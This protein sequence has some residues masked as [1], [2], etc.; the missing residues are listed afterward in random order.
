MTKTRFDDIL[1]NNYS[2]K[3]SEVFDTAGEPGNDKRPMPTNAARLQKLC[4]READREAGCLNFD[5]TPGELSNAVEPKI[6][7]KPNAL[8]D[9]LYTRVQKVAEEINS[10]RTE[11]NAEPRAKKDIIGWLIS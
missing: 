4:Q 3:E 2:A 9:H 5:A 7:A 11:L 1:R 6:P 8:S 10:L